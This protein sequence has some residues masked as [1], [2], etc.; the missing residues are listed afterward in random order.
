MDLAVTHP[1]RH[2]NIQDAVVALEN[3]GGLSPQGSDASMRARFDRID[4]KMANWT[5]Y[6]PVL[7]GT[8]WAKGTTGSTADGIHCVTNGVV[9]F[10]CEI[11]FGTGAT[12][13]AGAPKI[14]LPFTVEATFSATSYRGTVQG[15]I[16]DVAPSGTPYQ[17]IGD[18][19]S[20]TI[21][22]ACVNSASAYAAYATVTSTAPMNWAVSDY[23]Q[24]S[25][26][27]RKA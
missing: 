6:T 1:Q 11:T 10:A 20:T 8:G 22:L 19:E 18:L 23:I 15:Q 17:A 5:A 12:F 2:I 4:G 27:Y 14:S 21:A 7:S 25:G 26:W 13:G 16:V 9:F 3:T 24:M